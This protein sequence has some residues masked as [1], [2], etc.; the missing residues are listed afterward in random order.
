MTCEIIRS[1]LDRYWNGE[2]VGVRRDAVSA[3]VEACRDCRRS[4]AELEEL[5]ALL[6]STIPIPPLLR[7]RLVTGVVERVWERIA[8]S[9]SDATACPPCAD[10][11][12]AKPETRAV[13][14]RI[15]RLPVASYPCADCLAPAGSNWGKCGE[16]RT[17]A[18]RCAV[19]SI[20][21][22]SAPGRAAA[23]AT[24]RLRVILTAG[25]FLIVMTATVDTWVRPALR[26]FANV[27]RAVSRLDAPRSSGRTVLDSVATVMAAASI[28]DARSRRTAMVGDRGP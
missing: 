5:Y 13:R 2:I 26:L 12:P 23:S 20:R 8:G 22:P 28:G 17:R 1:A 25:L 11:E 19:T 21:V 18:V 15:G 14:W 7:R 4:L 6:E 16:C 24:S 27:T 10:L 3:H 9:R